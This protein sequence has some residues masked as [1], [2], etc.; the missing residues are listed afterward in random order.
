MGEINFWFI[1]GLKLTFCELELQSRYLVVSTRYVLCLYIVGGQILNLGVQPLRLVELTKYF[2]PPELR[3]ICRKIEKKN[4]YNNK[5]WRIKWY[6]CSLSLSF[7]RGH[8]GVVP[9]FIRGFSDIPKYMFFRRIVFVLMLL[10]FSLWL[11]FI[12]KFLS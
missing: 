9:H 11:V 3:N 5:K 6:V 2:S 12:I 4:E 10:Q 1:I 8:Q 7:K